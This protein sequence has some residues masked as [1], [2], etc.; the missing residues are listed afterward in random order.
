MPPLV[1][2]SGQPRFDYR[3]SGCGYGINVS[4]LPPLCPMCKGAEWE[5]GLGRRATTSGHRT[6]QRGERLSTADLGP[7]PGSTAA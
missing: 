2:P 5:D 3:C 4:E 6:R 7:A 1:L